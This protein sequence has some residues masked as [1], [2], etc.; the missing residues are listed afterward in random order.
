MIHLNI[1]DKKSHRLSRSAL[2]CSTPSKSRGT[3]P[4]LNIHTFSFENLMG[5][6]A[7][8]ESQE[9]S[10]EALKQGENA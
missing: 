2:Y 3:E 1:V 8:S 7:N 10:K 6:F 4:S 5:K 9:Y